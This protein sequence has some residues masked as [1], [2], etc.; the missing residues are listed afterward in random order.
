MP[1]GIDMPM[2]LGAAAM[3]ASTIIEATNAQLL[4]RLRLGPE[5][6]L[7]SASAGTL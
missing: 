1:W 3:S 4:R 6:G 5:Q 7:A 2:A